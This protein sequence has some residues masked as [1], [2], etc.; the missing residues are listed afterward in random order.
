MKFWW[1]MHWIFSGQRKI[2][3]GFFLNIKTFSLFLVKRKTL[4]ELKKVQLI[5][6]IMWNNH[7][8]LQFLIKINKK[9][10]FL[11]VLRDPKVVSRLFKCWIAET[12]T[13]THMDTDTDTSHV[14]A[15]TSSSHLSRACTE[16]WTTVLCSFIHKSEVGV[17]CGQI[18]SFL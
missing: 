5:E 16:L 8:K 18:S 14:P 2:Q 17:F 7:S 1:V 15:I 10:C 4:S 11:P 3:T 9:F 13:E 6:C 12:D